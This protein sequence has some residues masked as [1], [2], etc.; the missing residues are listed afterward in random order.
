MPLSLAIGDQR[1]SLPPTQSHDLVKASDIGPFIVPQLVNAPAALHMKPRLRPLSYQ[2]PTK[3]T[4]ETLGTHHPA[5]IWTKM[6]LTRESQ[7]LSLL[8][9]CHSP[10]QPGSSRRSTER[11]TGP[12]SKALH[13]TDSSPSRVQSPTLDPRRATQPST[14]D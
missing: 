10:S 4:P 2:L 7:V 5:C 8:L 6:P 14:Q 13:S 9:G 12:N 3:G 11:T 1:I